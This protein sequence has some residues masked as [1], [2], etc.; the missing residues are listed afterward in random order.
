MLIRDKQ[1]LWPCFCV[2]RLQSALNMD[3]YGSGE[4]PPN[5]LANVQ[6]FKSVSAKMQYWLDK[7]TPHVQA[8]WAGLS[9][10]IIVYGIR[11]FFLQV[12]K[13]VFLP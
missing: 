10:L 2:R 5:P 9:L 12:S 4:G 3:A 6:L 1:I 11:V 8:R 7:T 13:S